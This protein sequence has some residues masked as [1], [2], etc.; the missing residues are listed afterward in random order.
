MSEQLEILDSINFMT[1]KE[2][3]EL[4]IP[5]TEE[6]DVALEK[7]LSD[8]E[9]APRSEDDD[10]PPAKEPGQTDKWKYHG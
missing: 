5:T 7:L 10:P 1:F 9:R 6:I 4:I 3:D 8:I 2:A